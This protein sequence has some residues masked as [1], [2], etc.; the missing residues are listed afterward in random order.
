MKV[1]GL[2]HGS[3]IIGIAVGDTLL[4]VASPVKTIKC[5]KFQ[6]DA[7]QLFELAADYQVQAFVLGLPLNMDGSSGPRVQ[8]VKTFASNLKQLQNIPIYFQDE[9]YSSQAVNREMLAANLTRQQR[10]KKI[11]ALAACWILQGWL[12]LQ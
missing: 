6:K 1:F 8:S 5:T 11:D 9:R 4:K 7:T 3:K 12:E 2:D 10:G